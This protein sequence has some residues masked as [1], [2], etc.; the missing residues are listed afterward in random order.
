MG[1]IVG[2]K[3]PNTM[4]LNIQL[5]HTV[6][7]FVPGIE[8]IVHSNNWLNK[9]VIRFCPSLVIYITIGCGR[10]FQSWMVEGR[11]SEGMS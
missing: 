7:I 11:R 3:T 6:A 2:Q 9:R 8:Y 10:V 5:L 1:D 4:I